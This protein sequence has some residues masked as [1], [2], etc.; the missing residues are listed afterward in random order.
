[1]TYVKETYWNSYDYRVF[2]EL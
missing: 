1:G 2:N